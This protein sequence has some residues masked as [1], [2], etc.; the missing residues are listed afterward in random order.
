MIHQMPAGSGRYQVTIT[1]RN[2]GWAVVDTTTDK[3]VAPYVL[4][5]VPLNQQTYF[6]DMREAQHAAARL[7]AATR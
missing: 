2:P 7:N 5:G 3:V 4:L 1:D 6:A